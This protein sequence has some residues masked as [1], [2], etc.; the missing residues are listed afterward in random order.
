MSFVTTPVT[1]TTTPTT[2]ARRDL[3]V[4]KQTFPFFDDSRSLRL[5]FYHRA[6]FEPVQL[7]Q[8]KQVRLYSDML[9]R[10]VLASLPLIVP[11]LVAFRARATR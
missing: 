9:L 5:T 1:T 7:T 10:E 11:I 4:F 8:R 2:T 6:F 3:P